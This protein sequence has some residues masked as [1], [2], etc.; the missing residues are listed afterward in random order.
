[1]RTEPK[2]TYCPKLRRVVLENFDGWTRH[3]LYARFGHDANGK[4]RGL[5][6]RHRD[7]SP[8]LAA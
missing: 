1:M 6:F 7:R 4:P 2:A 8:A 3:A 5:A